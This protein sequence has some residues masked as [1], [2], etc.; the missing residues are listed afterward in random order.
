MMVST[1]VLR[2]HSAVWIHRPHESHSHVVRIV[3]SVDAAVCFGDGPL[4]GFHDGERVF[5]EI[6]TGSGHWQNEVPATIREVA[7]IRVSPDTL[8]ELA[9]HVPLG[10]SLA[11][12]QAAIEQLRA[13]RLLALLPNT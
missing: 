1:A 4:R 12:V 9:G 2:V 6:G 10:G 11:D 13:R 7:A 8:V 5:L 3:W